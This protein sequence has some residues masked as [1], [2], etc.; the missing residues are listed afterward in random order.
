MTSI[1][2]LIP[3]V[4]EVKMIIAA[5]CCAAVLGG[6]FWVKHEWDE[7]KV[8]KT[9]NATLTENNKILQENND[10][11]KGNLG[12]CTSANST[13][14]ATIASLIAERN[15]A[16]NAVNVLAQQQKSNVAAIGVLG[17]KLSD[18]E[19]NAANDGPLAPDLR[20]TVRG[21]EGSK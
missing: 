15:A 21:I 9:N 3:G 6:G 4:A 14:N 20:E 16:Q 18:L 19:K 7:L 17:K 13:D 2:D 8:L 12:T 11:L 5:A 1:T 10:V